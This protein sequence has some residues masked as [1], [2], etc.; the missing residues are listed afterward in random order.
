LQTGNNE[1]AQSRIVGQLPASR[2]ATPPPGITLSGHRPIPART[3][4]A[5][6]LPTHRRRHATKTPSDP[7]K[8][9][10]PR[11]PNRDLFTLRQP[12]PN[13]RHPP[14]QSQRPR[15]LGRC[16][17]IWTPPIFAARSEILGKDFPISRLGHQCNQG[18]SRPCRIIETSNAVN[19][20]CWR[21]W[22]RLMGDG[23]PR[24][25]ES[26]NHPVGHQCGCV[27]AQDQ[28]VTGADGHSR[29]G[30]VLQ[31]RGGRSDRRRRASG[32]RREVQ[33]D[34]ARNRE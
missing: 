4:V 30:E 10:T 28:P 32:I 29:C 26:T 7:S 20:F 2:T 33:R 5:F 14:L 15:S 11:D 6:H 9:L 31:C 34:Y 21:S 8:G 12:Q 27:H 22:G 13:T 23:G 19:A 25:Q 24:P 17:R 3:P 18:G 16:N 1:L